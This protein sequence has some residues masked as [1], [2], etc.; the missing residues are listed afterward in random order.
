MLQVQEDITSSLCL[1]NHKILRSS[2][3]RPNIHY[4]VKYTGEVHPLLCSI[5]QQLSQ[6]SQ[7]S[8]NWISDACCP[9]RGVP[10]S[11]SDC[12]P[13]R[14]FGAVVSSAA[15]AAAAT[16]TF[17]RNRLRQEAADH[18]DSR[19]GSF[20]PGKRLFSS[21]QLSLALSSH[22]EQPFVLL[23]KPEDNFYAHQSHTRLVCERG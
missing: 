12:E 15:A 13:P 9:G 19:P 16:R 6:A 3:N 1:R 2:F 17:L 10:H 7:G 11:R 8:I 23:G 14:H 22:F 5:S 21:Q 18:G 20:E 4:S